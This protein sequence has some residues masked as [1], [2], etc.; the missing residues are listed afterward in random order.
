MRGYT[1]CT[2]SDTPADTNI[3]ESL[4]QALAAEGLMTESQ[5]CALR[6]RIANGEMKA[7]DWVALVDAQQTN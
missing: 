2:M 5:A 4:V 1:G 7:A 3:A 6:D